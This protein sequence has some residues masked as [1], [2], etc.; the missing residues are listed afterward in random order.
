M[1]CYVFKW[2]S[3]RPGRCIRLSTGSVRLWLLL[4][5]RVQPVTRK[6]FHSL[7]PL[8]QNMKYHDCFCFI[9]MEILC[10]LIFGT[11]VKVRSHFNTTLC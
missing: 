6:L 8:S 7:F 4:P 1:I 9:C 11:L 2:S 10:L 3:V 5:K